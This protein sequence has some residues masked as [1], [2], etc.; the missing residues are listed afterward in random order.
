MT[1]IRDPQHWRARADNSI[2]HG[3]LT[4]SKRPSA[5]VDGVYPTHLTKGVGAHVW[6]LLGKKYLDFCCANGTNLVGYGNPV[7]A[8]SAYD[9]LRAGALF[10][11]SST[12]EVEA[13]EKV[14]EM[15]PWIERLRFL[16]TG[17]EACQAAIRIARAATGRKL[18]LSEGYHGWGDEFVSLTPPAHGCIG[19]MTLGLRDLNFI[20]RDLAAVI[21]EPVML[22]AGPTRRKWLNDLKARC[23]DMG[24]V[25]IFDEIITGFRWQKYSVAGHWGIRPDISLYGKAMAGGL[26]LAVVGGRKEIMECEDEYF[27]SSTFAG[28]R[29]SLAGF[30]AMSQLLHSHQYRLGEL[31]ETGEK[32]LEKFNAISELIQIEGYA[33]RGAFRGHPEMIGK[34][35]Q[36]CCKAGILFGASWFW[37]FP[38]M[39]EQ[40]VIEVCE[41][42]IWKVKRGVQLEGRLPQ[43]PFAAKV[44]L[45]SALG[46]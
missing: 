33:T 8:Q 38:H 23:N 6:D 10:S 31:W 30:L 9:A 29:T 40:N 43:S 27:V 20:N 2:A 4:N 32:F 3:A 21:V 44:R 14:Q 18:V 13:A 46:S 41:E 37:A 16:K 39:Q 25:L 17:S 42:A 26:P 11:L 19:G 35:W 22:D 28:D 7:V 24:V 5:F 34:F 12:L 36:E 15:L 45:K 1:K